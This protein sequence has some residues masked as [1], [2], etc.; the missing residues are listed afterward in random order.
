MQLYV[1]IVTDIKKI[2]SNLGY[3]TIK[4]PVAENSKYPDVQFVVEFGPY[5]ASVAEPLVLLDC[6]L[7]DWV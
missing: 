6:H 1:H 4:Q 2:L 7:F 3:G 5:I